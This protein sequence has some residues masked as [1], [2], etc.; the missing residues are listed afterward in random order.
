M[1]VLTTEAEYIALSSATREAVWLRSLLGELGA[2]IDGAPT[3][4]GNNKSAITLVHHPSVH[5]QTKHIA[6]HAHFTRER[7][8]LWELAVEWVSAHNM[9]ADG[10]TKALAGPAHENVIGMIGLCQIVARKSVQ[11]GS[12]EAEVRQDEE[13]P[14]RAMIR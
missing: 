14:E 11:N 3:L 4:Y 6:V 13:E 7:V 12:Q 8:A 1:L 2:P 5:H 9:V 10:L